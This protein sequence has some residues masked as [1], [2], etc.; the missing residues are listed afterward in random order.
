LVGLEVSLV[1]WI[2]PHPSGSI[3]KLYILPDASVS[4]LSGLHSEGLKIKIKAAPRDGETNG[5]LTEFLARILKINKSGIHFLRVRV[6]EMKI[7]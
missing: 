4:C 3:V 6:Q 1:K 7:Y 5:E 2:K